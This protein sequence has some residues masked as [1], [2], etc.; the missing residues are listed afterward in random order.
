M[1]KLFFGSVDEI[2]YFPCGVAPAQAPDRMEMMHHQK[3]FGVG[4]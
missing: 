4:G 2:K 1:F 3:V